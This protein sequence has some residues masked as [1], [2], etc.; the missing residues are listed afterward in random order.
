MRHAT[1]VWCEGTSGTRR[2]GAHDNDEGIRRQSVIRSDAERSREAFAAYGPVT[3]A[4]IVM[5]RSN[6]VSR[7]R[8]RG[9]TVAAGGI[10]RAV[11]TSSAL[12]R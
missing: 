1:R 6:G 10:R 8:P 2:Q 5:D 7:A 11:G 3:S 4:D 12:A 9:A